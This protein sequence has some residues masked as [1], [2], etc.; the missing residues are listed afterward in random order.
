MSMYNL[1]AP[2]IVQHNISGGLGFKVRPGVEIH[3]AGY[4]ALE[5]DITGPMMRPMGIPGTSVKNAMS[6][7]S[8]L[9]GFTFTP[10]KK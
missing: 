6:E 9:V 7:K 5:N 8:I 3:L 10:T 4:V 1:P 2:A